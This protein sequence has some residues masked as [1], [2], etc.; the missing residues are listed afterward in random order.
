MHR[1]ADP[2]D[3]KT[4]E[5]L[6][7]K[8]RNGNYSEAFKYEF[9]QFYVELKEFFNAVGL[10]K[11]LDMIKS[12]FSGDNKLSHKINLFLHE[13]HIGHFSNLSLITE[14]R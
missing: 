5:E 9:E 11:L 8:A 13:K 4:C 12:G 14:L 1:C 7:W 10:E 2:G 6:I 3:L